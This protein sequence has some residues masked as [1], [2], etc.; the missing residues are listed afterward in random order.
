MG[1]KKPK[2]GLANVEGRRRREA[3]WGRKARLD[4]P[5]VGAPAYNRFLDLARSQ[6][7]VE[8]APHE[9]WQLAIGGE[10]E[11][12]QLTISQFSDARAQWLIQ[13]AAEAHP[14][15]Q[16]NETVLDTQRILTD[17]KD[18]NDC[19]RGDHDHPGRAKTRKP[20]HFNHGVDGTDQRHGKDKEME[21]RIESSVIGKRLR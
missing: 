13:D 2:W 3:E 9:F 19:C 4:A 17:A 12:D 10:T 7:F 14:L 1:G 8:T 18:G 11:P 21:R 16:T 5:I 6:F 15:F 20:N